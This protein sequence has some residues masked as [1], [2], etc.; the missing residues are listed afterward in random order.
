MW[1]QIAE[2][3]SC[4]GLRFRVDAHDDQIVAKLGKKLPACTARCHSTTTSNRDRLPI[5][6]ATCDRSS[7]RHSLGTNRQGKAS[8]FDVAT[9]EGFAA[10]RQD[11]GSHLKVAVR[12]MSLQTHSQRRV[13]QVAK[14]AFVDVAELIVHDPISSSVM[15]LTTSGLAAMNCSESVTT[16]VNILPNAEDSRGE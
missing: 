5:S 6:L 8:V 9:D 7:R 2:L 15:R 10:A 11:R 13:D 1:Q 4:H 16:L 3:V 14:H 12:C